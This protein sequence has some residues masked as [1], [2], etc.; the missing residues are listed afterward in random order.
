VDGEYG[1]PEWCKEAEFRNVCDQY[2]YEIVLKEQ[3]N[4]LFLSDS[5]QV[6]NFTKKYLYDPFNTPCLDTLYSK[7]IDWEK[8]S[9][10][11]Q[12][13]IIS[14]YQSA[15]RELSGWDCASGCIWDEEAVARCVLVSE[16]T[17]RI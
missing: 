12:G 5:E 6:I 13:I 1:W 7:W 14:P 8:V 11:Y 3:R 15:C 17:R 9:Q 4:V 10:K 2:K 16:P